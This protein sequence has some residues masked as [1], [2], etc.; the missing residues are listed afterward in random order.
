MTPSP[1]I[2]GCYW[3]DE[4]LS[5]KWSVWVMGGVGDTS[6]TVMTRR[7]PVVLKKK[8]RQEL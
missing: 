8:R 1:E 7:A 3:A 4:L 6:E 5:K 2:L